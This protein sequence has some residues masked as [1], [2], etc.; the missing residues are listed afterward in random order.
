MSL[1][2]F[3]L[4]AIQKI[5]QHIRQSLTLPD[6]ERR[7]EAWSFPDDVDEL[8]IPESL[9][10]L[11]DLFK[12]GSALST[13][14]AGFDEEGRWLLSTVNP[15]AALLQIPSL[16]L[17]AGWRWVTFL[18]RR[19]TGGINTVWAVPEE[20]ATVAQ[21]ELAMENA[22]DRGHPPQPE[23]GLDDPMAALTGDRSPMSFVIAS[24]LRRELKEF[25][26]LGADGKWQNHRPIEVI[27]NQMKW[28]WKGDPPKDLAPKVKVLPDGR[29]AVEFFTCRVK[30]PIVICRHIDQYDKR[31]DY[32]AASS[33]RAIALMAAKVQQASQ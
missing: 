25:G 17:R 26:A 28:Q 21:L 15:A 4:T 24:I 5:Q 31:D 7:L 6:S 30:P 12:F 13:E 20:M 10:D 3:P 1:H 29:V 16:Q 23:Q 18:H 33:D 19:K 22:S 32:V 27:P 9:D 11:G 2:K 14:S 8:P